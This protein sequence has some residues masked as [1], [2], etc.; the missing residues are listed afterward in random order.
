[1][2]VFRSRARLIPMRAKREEIA[3]L[4]AM[5]CDLLGFGMLIADIQIRSESLMPRGWPTGAVIGV[6][7]AST[8][9]IQTLASPR[10]GRLSDRI[11]RK[12]VVVFCTFLSALAMLVYGFAG[13]IWIVFLSRILSGLGAANVAVAQ[14]FISDQ[15]DPARRTAALGRVG[16]AISTGLVVGPPLG[17]FL[18]YQGKIILGASNLP[19]QL[20]LGLVAAV[21]SG[22][23]ALGLALALPNVPGRQADEPTG[24]KPEKRPLFDFSLL[25]E[26][27]VLR[28]YVV[29][30][31]VAWL[32]LATLE[33]TFAR[34]IQRLF[35]YDQLQFGFL[36]GY[37][38]LL[39][40]VIQGV[41]LA[42][43]VKRWSDSALLRT[44]YLSQGLGLALNPASVL[45][46]SAVPPLV[47]LFV[48][49]TLFAVG[50]GI[51][52]P[53]INGICS[54]LVPEK[55]QGELFGLMQ[56][57][58]SLGFVIGP[59]V[60]GALFD[61]IPAAPYLVAGA[62]C[63]GAAILVPSRRG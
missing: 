22:V 23:G 48:A 7:L 49:S 30:A 12:P 17:G 5:F 39:G 38:S 60:G 54:A 58:R 41:L 32:S 53:T 62:V 4:V 26:F 2:R 29:I 47:S 31:T 15:T 56:G 8:F 43:L 11:G 27:P 34:L 28:S 14:A 55:R 21:A 25:R 3:I 18:A 63:V 10:W 37:E 19:A 9:V 46:V 40:I 16:A 20:L 61:W 51:A 24:E 35:G 44:A 33:G 36:F 45:F 13:S 42:W 6:V 52:N 59:V 57:T 50:A 1:M